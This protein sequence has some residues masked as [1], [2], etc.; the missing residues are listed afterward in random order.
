MVSDY[1]LLTCPRL[2]GTI[3]HS[4]RFLIYRIPRIFFKIGPEKTRVSTNTFV[5]YIIF[6]KGVTL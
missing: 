5:K 4:Q 2:T 1:S 3:D 6:Q